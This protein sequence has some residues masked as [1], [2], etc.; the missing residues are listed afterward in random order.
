MFTY[1]LESVNGNW[2]TWSY[3]NTCSATCNKGTQRRNRNCDSPAPS[4]SG[5]GCSGRSSQTKPCLIKGCPGKITKYKRFTDH[6]DRFKSKNCSKVNWKDWR[7]LNNNSKRLIL[8]CISDKNRLK[9]YYILTR[10]ALADAYSA[11]PF[12][13]D[14]KIKA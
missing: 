13:F 10:M 14:V 6:Y 2:G 12:Y 7:T 1:L 5:L 4:A 3:W 8:T 11:F 9:L